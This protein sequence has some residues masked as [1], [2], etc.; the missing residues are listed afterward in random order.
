MEKTEFLT[1]LKDRGF[2][3][4]LINGVPTV[5]M[6]SSK[7]LKDVKALKK[8]CGYDSSFAVKYDGKAAGIDEEPE[9]EAFKDNEEDAFADSPTPVSVTKENVPSDDS[10]DS[11]SLLAS[12]PFNDV[13]DFGD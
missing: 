13:W 2:K 7:G 1:L 9:T 12:T 6:V 10:D 3:A 11:G 8:E 5:H 4:E